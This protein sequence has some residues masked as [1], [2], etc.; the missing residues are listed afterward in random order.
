MSRQARVVVAYAVVKVLDPL[1]GKPTVVGFPQGAVLPA[2]ADSQNVADLVRREYCEWVDPQPSGWAGEPDLPVE[3]AEPVTVGASAVAQVNEPT[4]V[5]TEVANGKPKPYASKVEW[6]DYAVAHRPEGM[7]EYD[8]R[9]AAEAKTK[10]E[11]IAEY[12]Q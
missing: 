1:S 9:S 12:G 7:S 4:Q 6:V 5:A 3:E 11:L 2:Y 8:A 10:D